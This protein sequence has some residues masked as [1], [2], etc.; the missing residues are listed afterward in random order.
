MGDVDRQFTIEPLDACDNGYHYVPVETLHAKL[1]EIIGDPEKTQL[2]LKLLQGVADDHARFMMEAGLD[3]FHKRK[4]Y[5]FEDVFKDL[6]NRARTVRRYFD[7]IGTTGE[8]IAVKRVC[9]CCQED[10]T[11]HKG[12]G[13]CYCYSWCPHAGE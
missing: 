8:R 9:A 1:T 6:T 5:P 10:R 11:E 13:D 12:V 2:V 4:K 3:A 7:L